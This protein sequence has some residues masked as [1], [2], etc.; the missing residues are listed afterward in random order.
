MKSTVAAAKLVGMVH[1]KAT[2]VR[3]SAQSGLPG[4]FG[5][6]RRG[7]GGCKCS[8]VCQLWQSWL[9]SV[10]HLPGAQK[11]AIMTRKKRRC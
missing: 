5:H 3:C 8:T 1:L 7:G 11:R 6:G 9:A 4:E 10:E 2:V